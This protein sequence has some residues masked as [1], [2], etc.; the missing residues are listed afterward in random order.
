MNLKVV[1]YS[2]GKL[3]KFLGALMGIPCVLSLIYREPDFLPLAI[4]VAVTLL[5]GYLIERFCSRAKDE[6]IRHRE[7][8]A[9]VSLGWVVVAFFGTIPFLLAGTFSSFIDAY[10]ETRSLLNLQFQHLN[11]SLDKDF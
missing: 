7:A 3:I 1:F 9:I 6:E 11:S 8:F 4:S 5:G 10:F 2:V